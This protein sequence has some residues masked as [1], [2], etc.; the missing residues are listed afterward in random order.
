M[1]TNGLSLDDGTIACLPE[2]LAAIVRDGPPPLTA[3]DLDHIYA[4]GA[5]LYVRERWSEAQDVFRLLV[6]V[7]PSD[8]RGWIAL[9]ACHEAQADDERA[10]ALYQLASGASSREDSRRARL[11]LARVLAKTGRH[12]EARQILEAIVVENDDDTTFVDMHA[13]L[14]RCLMDTQPSLQPVGVGER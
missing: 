12:D 3:S 10:I 4:V 6:L 1:T 8:A 2:T 13:Q 7:H 5:D 9:A 11:Y 14:Q